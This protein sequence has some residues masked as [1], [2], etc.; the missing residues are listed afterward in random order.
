MDFQ[1]EMMEIY[2]L[3]DVNNS[4]S[5]S[6]TPPIS[7]QTTLLDPLDN[8]GVPLNTL[9]NDG[10]STNTS[11]K[12]C[13]TYASDS[14]DPDAKRRER[15]ERERVSARKRRQQRADRLKYLETYSSDLQTEIAFLKRRNAELEQE[16]IYRRGI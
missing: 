13:G 3:F 14:F 8:D 11:Q 9:D 16:L 10:E 4:Q 2:A 1:Q 5:Q 12:S 7:G 6:Q 15:L